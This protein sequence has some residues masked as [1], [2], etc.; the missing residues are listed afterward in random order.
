MDSEILCCEFILKKM[1]RSP[2]RNQNVEG[3]FRPV[4]NVGGGVPDLTCDSPKLTLVGKWFR[5]R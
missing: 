4:R 2:E 5:D 1:S 3:G